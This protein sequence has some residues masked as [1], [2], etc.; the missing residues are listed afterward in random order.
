M[1]AG[2]EVPGDRAGAADPTIIQEEKRSRR[3]VVAGLEV[4]GDR[5]GAADP[6]IIQEEKRSR[7][8]WSHRDSKSRAIEP[9]QRIDDRAGAADPTIKPRSSR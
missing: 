7:R 8:T 6:T 1:V 3:T 5:A 4:P 9:A 2:L